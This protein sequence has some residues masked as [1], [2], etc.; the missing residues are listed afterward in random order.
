MF[1]VSSASWAVS[2]TWRASSHT[3]VG[4]TTQISSGK[5][6]LQAYKTV[7]HGTM[8][9]KH[10]A[11]TV[12]SLQSNISCMGSRA[13]YIEVVCHHTGRPR[14]TITAQKDRMTFVLSLT[15]SGVSGGGCFFARGAMFGSCILPSS[16]ASPSCSLSPFAAIAATYRLW[17]T[18]ASRRRAAGDGSM[19]LSHRCWGYRTI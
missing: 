4:Q 2:T 19:L 13:L 10:M 16:F 15:A 11:H 8:C 9:G 5:T 12:P 17:L 14:K 18:S 6:G 3:R 1:I 7:S